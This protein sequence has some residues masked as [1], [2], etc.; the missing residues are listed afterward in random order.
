LIQWVD[1]DVEIVHADTSAFIAMADASA[2]WQHGDIQC[3][4]GLDLTSFD[5]VSVTNG[6]FVPIVVKPAAAV[7]LDNVML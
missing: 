3:L 5:F 4:S 2:N 1:D 7:W 6:S